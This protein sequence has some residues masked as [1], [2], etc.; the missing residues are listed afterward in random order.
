MAFLRRE[1]IGD[2]IRKINQPDLVVNDLA[3]VVAKLHVRAFNQQPMKRAVVFDERRMADQ[4]DFPQR[5]LQTVYRNL[6][7]VRVMLAKHFGGKRVNKGNIYTWK[8][9]GFQM[10][11]AELRLRRYVAEQELK[12][13]GAGTLSRE[14]EDWMRGG[15]VYR[16]TSAGGCSGRLGGIFWNG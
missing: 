3:F 16:G 7:E 14:V 12:G 8:K 9:S 15:R 10:W 11:Q 13:I 6:E 5:L 4:P 1:L 2:G